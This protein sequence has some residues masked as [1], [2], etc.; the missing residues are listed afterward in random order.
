MGGETKI[1]AKKVFSWKLKFE[2]IFT[3]KGLCHKKFYKAYKV[4]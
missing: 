3:S 4:N 1:E 2:K